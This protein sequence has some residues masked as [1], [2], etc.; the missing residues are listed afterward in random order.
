MWLKARFSTK[1]LTRSRT[2]ISSTRSWCFF[3]LLIAGVQSL[4]LWMVSNQVNVRCCILHLHATCAKKSKLPNLPVMCL[5]SLRITMVKY[6]SKA[7]SSTWPKTLLAPTISISCFQRVCLV[8]VFK[9]VKM[10]RLPV[11]SIPVSVCSLV[12]SFL[13]K[14]TCCSPISKMMVCQSNQRRTILS[15]QWCSS[16]AQR[17]LVLVIRH[18]SP[19]TLR[20]ILWTI[21]SRSSM[22]NLSAPWYLG[23]AIS[24]VRSLPILPNRVSFYAAVALSAVAQ[25]SA[26]MSCQS[27][28]GP[29]I[30]RSIWKSSWLP[31]TMMRPPDV[32][33]LVQCQP[34]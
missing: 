9:V 23:I 10:L 14:M 27:A 19:T 28:T 6:L 7:P 16:T 34:T 31:P 21:S 30:S 29:K 20:T 5:K 2:R 25:H 24:K 3:L 13:N 1:T 4:I 17:V 15:F 12:P 18:R 26:F 8:L 33:V 11:T 22:T 32:A